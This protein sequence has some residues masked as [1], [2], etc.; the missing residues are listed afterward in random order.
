MINML[1]YKI[2]NQYSN[3]RRENRKDFVESIKWKK[4]ENTAILSI[5]F[6]NFQNTKNLLDYLS[7]EINQNFDI[8]LIE[9]STKENEENKLLEYC[10]WKENVSI[11]KPI[12]N[13]WSAW[14]YALGME[15]IID[16]KYD[17]FFLV[18]DDVIFLDENIF[19][20]MVWKSDDE[21]LTFVNNCQNTRDAKD[22]EN[23]WKSRRV[24]IAWYP[25]N[26][27]EKI[28]IIDPR[29][30]FRWEDL[31]W[32][33]RIEK[34]IIKF[35]YKTEIVDKNY[36]H[37]YLKSVNGNYTWFYFSI[38][39]Q[40]LS[41]EKNLKNN[42]QFFIVLFFYLWTAISKN[43][44][45]KD[46]LI[47]KSFIDAFS[48]FLKHN[49][50]WDNNIN[51]I[52]WFINNNSKEEKKEWLDKLEISNISKDFYSSAKILWITW[53]DR[54]NIKYSKNIKNLWKNGLLISSSSTVFY[55]ISLL[56]K[57][58]VC[59]NEFDLIGNKVS[60]SQ[61]INWNRT[62]NLIWIIASFIA[63]VVLIIMVTFIIILS[64]GFNKWLKK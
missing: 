44:I 58:V 30:F 22:K 31:E 48:D 42:Y 45:E 61:Y 46:N 53:V 60:V 29:Y 25:V 13:L 9:N 23:K 33:S 2:K 62:I 18:E 54:E 11:I 20:D 15:Y 27:I 47:L 1:D 35:W 57:K 6:N 34:W 19:S 12:N 10:S 63:S 64:I 55:T 21:T 8:V 32:W 14:W 7:K 5:H 39:N 52:E 38:R 41:V 28:W 43:F 26:F 40:L 17:Y 3:I 36:L 37:P 59:I 50:S 49:F 4:R 16:Q 56:A 51:K 24:Q